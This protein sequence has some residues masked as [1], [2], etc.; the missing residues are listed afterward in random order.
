MH[1]TLLHDF[2][3]STEWEA[4]CD[5]LCLNTNSYVSIIATVRMAT[6]EAAVYKHLQDGESAREAPEGPC[7]MSYLMEARA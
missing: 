7:K 6:V 1:A 3:V 2:T 4:S 5:I